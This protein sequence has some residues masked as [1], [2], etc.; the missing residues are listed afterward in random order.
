MSE[1]GILG[2]F[3]QVNALTEE[4]QEL[5]IGYYVPCT[6]KILVVT[7]NNTVILEPG[8]RVFVQPS[9]QEASSNIFN[10]MI[11]DLNTSITDEMLEVVDYVTH[12]GKLD[13]KS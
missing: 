8:D 13:Y 11:G 12:T 2:E 4:E 5:E 1:R 10:A 6:S 3:D 9:L 7:D